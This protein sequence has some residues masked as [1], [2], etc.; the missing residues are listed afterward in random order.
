MSLRRALHSSRTAVPPET[1]SRQA[2][3]VEER[4]WSRR[5][6]PR[7][8]LRAHWPH[9]TI[10][11]VELLKEV[12]QLF[13][14]EDKGYFTKDDL[15]FVMEA[16]GGSPT[17]QELDAVMYEL[18]S[19]G[20]S[21]VDFPEFL[22]KFL[23]ATDEKELLSV[24]H[25]LA[26]QEGEGNDDRVLTL[27]AVERSFQYVGERLT[28]EDK[29]YLEIIFRGA[30]KDGNGRLDIKE[31]TAYL[32]KMDDELFMG[33]AGA[34]SN[35]LA[36]AN[37]SGGTKGFRNGR[38]GGGSAGAGTSQRRSNGDDGAGD[39]GAGGDIS[40]T[41][42]AGTDVEV[43][44][45]MLTNCQVLAMATRALNG[46]VG[47]GG[48]QDDVESITSNQRNSFLSRLTRRHRRSSV[49][50]STI[51]AIA[52]QLASLGVASS[53]HAVR[54][55]SM[56]SAA[57]LAAGGHLQA[58]G[59]DGRRSVSISRTAM[60]LHMGVHQGAAPGPGGTPHFLVEG[61]SSSAL[62][63]VSSTSQLGGFLGAEEHS[64][65]P[66]P[67]T[68]PVALSCGASFGDGVAAAYGVGPDGVA[69]AVA[70]LPQYQHQQ[71]QQHPG[72]ALALA[73]MACGAPGGATGGGMIEGHNHNGRHGHASYHQHPHVHPHPYPH[74]NHQQQPPPP[75]FHQR[76]TQSMS[77]TMS[78][79]L[80]Q[81]LATPA[82]LRDSDEP[83]SGTT[84]PFSPG[85][86]T[87][88]GGMMAQ[89]Q[90]RPAG[91]HVGYAG[92][93]AGGMRSPAASWQKASVIQE[94]PEEGDSG[95]GGAGT[96]GVMQP[97]VVMA[98]QQRMDH[99]AEMPGRTSAPTRFARLASF[100]ASAHI[101]PQPEMEEDGG[102]GGG[103]AVAAAEVSSVGT[104]G[105]AGPFPP[106]PM[107]LG[108]G[109]DGRLGHRIGG[110]WL[111]AAVFSRQRSLGPG[112]AAAGG[113][114]VASVQ[115][116]SDAASEPASR[117][118]PSQ[119]PPSP[120]SQV[121][122][123]PTDGD[124]ERRT[125]S[126]GSWGLAAGAR[127]AIG[128]LRRASSFGNSQ[129]VAGSSVSINGAETVGNG[130]GLSH[131]CSRTR[132]RSPRPA[133]AVAAAAAAAAGHIATAATG[134]G[135]SLAAPWRLTVEVPGSD[136]P[137]SSKLASPAEL[138]ATSG[139]GAGEDAS[140]LTSP[141]SHPPLPLLTFPAGT[142][143]ASLPV[144]S[145]GGLA[146]PPAAILTGSIA[147]TAVVSAAAS[148]TAEPGPPSF[149][150]SIS[151]PPSPAAHSGVSPASAI[152]PSRAAH[153][154][155]MQP[156]FRPPGSSYSRSSAA[157]DPPSP[158][159]S[160]LG[161]Q[162]PPH[163]HHQSLQRT[164]PGPDTTEFVMAPPSRTLRPQAPQAP[165]NMSPRGSGSALG[166][167]PARSLHR[168][169]SVGGSSRL[170]VSSARD[171]PPVL[172]AHVQRQQSLQ[173]HH[174]HAP[175]PAPAP[176]HRLSQQ[177][178]PQQLSYAPNALLRVPRSPDDSGRPHRLSHTGLPNDDPHYLSPQELPEQ[179]Q[180][181]SGASSPMRRQ[182]SSP[183]GYGGL[184]SPSALQ[185][186]GLQVRLRTETKSGSSIAG[187]S[188]ATAPVPASRKVHS[189]TSQA[190]DATSALA[191]TEVAPRS[192]WA[193]VWASAPSLPGGAPSGGSGK[194]SGSGD[195]VE[196][197]IGA[198]YG[199]SSG[200]GRPRN[201]HGGEGAAQ[202][203][204]HGGGP[205][206]A[207]NRRREA[208]DLVIETTTPPSGQLHGP[209]HRQ[210]PLLRHQ[211]VHRQEQQQELQQQLDQQWGEPPQSRHN[212]Q[213]EEQ[214][215]DQR[216]VQREP[217]LGQQAE[218]EEEQ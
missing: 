61:S 152:S 161:P 37:I 30:D 181:A 217:G 156:Y 149:S 109:G 175:L 164:P 22:T 143:A 17:P 101:P 163:I 16:M 24:F 118:P 55:G 49:N 206:R 32:E 88:G 80:A 62:R 19:N 203:Q 147:A 7:E 184:H 107:R 158:S 131:K 114:A 74:L 99:R 53:G 122:G 65:Q 71:Q 133:A 105:H 9:L 160:S 83:I 93:A 106:Q 166:A 42:G 113:Q 216:Q 27:T 63:L 127:A 35:L 159:S 167:G 68:A 104:Q 165:G 183:R 119:P 208:S 95:Y 100:P 141:F 145:G 215:K 137:G 92:R 135:G 192:P 44:A 84:S 64:P 3:S 169:G 172:P 176:P 20:D 90:E 38:Y 142:A 212:L 130:A 211:H 14:T 151:Q 108:S 39:G 150:G 25:Q 157:G 18:D 190:L 51:A 52:G 33:Q 214:H 40:G 12:F 79:S 193:A 15:F 82:S 21:V 128:W 205:Q 198:A 171:S 1:G 34:L 5:K 210:Q 112:A 197:E 132:V 98:T 136:S 140:T 204:P 4:P 117:P 73:A 36:A 178:L 173:H 110:S 89:G 10:Q 182:L 56:N 47:G 179:Q 188:C 180:I 116:P 46:H 144:A 31:F 11:Q 85:S 121:S 66:V 146:S 8:Q 28:D 199:D 186:Q 102:G 77:A 129:T 123:G 187:G 54:A 218:L 120:V 168:S 87:T 202:A 154:A 115:S 194:G 189:S 86:F 196:A 134:T 148:L 48:L 103:D 174:H 60:H 125:G 177:G 13:D 41:A 207:V 26:I 29:K 195:G 45:S 59:S 70:G 170:A 78:A 191:A 209:Q 2:A 126:S 200:E 124:S 50:S 185:Y 139:P 94:A 138:G 72:R 69:A 213:R 81:P 57:C 153:L 43:A 162:Q 76:R 96:T 111:M 23:T 155:A 58:D 91:A 67:A 97:V 75:P 201:L 6:W